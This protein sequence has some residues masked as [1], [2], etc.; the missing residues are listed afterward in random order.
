VRRYIASYNGN[1][2]GTGDGL[3][4]QIPPEGSYVMAAL[5]APSG[6]Q[7]ITDYDFT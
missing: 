1:A 2:I 6:I 5:I 4:G 7:T 3:V